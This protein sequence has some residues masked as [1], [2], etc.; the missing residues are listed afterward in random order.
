MGADNIREVAQNPRQPFRIILSVDVLDVFSLLFLRPRITD[1]ID[2]E[3][4]G[5]RQI[6][7]PV[8]LKIA[9]QFATSGRI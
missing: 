3:A 7:E 8:Q 4:Q 1:V 9:F 5:L 6:I 2:V